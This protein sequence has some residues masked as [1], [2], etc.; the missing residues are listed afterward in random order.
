MAKNKTAMS[1][2]MLTQNQFFL[3]KIDTVIQETLQ[4]KANNHYEED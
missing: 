4:Q 1:R 2:I 3:P